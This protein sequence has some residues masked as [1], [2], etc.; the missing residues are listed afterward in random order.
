MEFS[1]LGRNDKKQTIKNSIMK[2]YLSIALLAFSMSV[3]VSCVSNFLDPE[4]P[5]N[6]QGSIS[7]P[8][9]ISMSLN[10]DEDIIVHYTDASIESSVCLKNKN[11]RDLPAGLEKNISV[12]VRYGTDKN[13][14]DNAIDAILDEKESDYRKYY[15][16][17]PFKANLTGLEDGQVYYYSIE[18][19]YGND[20]PV[21]CDAKKLFTFPAGPV[22]LDIKSGVLWCSGNLGAD[23][24]E[25]CGGR[26]A[27]AETSVKSENALY[28][29][30][31]YEWCSGKKDSI[32]KYCSSGYWGK[33]GFVDN[34]SEMQESDDA[35]HVQLG[36]GYHIP[37]ANDWI[38]LEEQCGWE[39][40]KVNG[41]NGWLVRSK[42]NPDDNKKVIFLPCTGIQ[43]GGSVM[44][45]NSSGYYWTANSVSGEYGAS[46][47]AY[48]FVIVISGI[49]GHY[50]YTTDRC[51]GESIRP[52]KK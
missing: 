33:D 29:W 51:Y 21:I 11:Y 28:D 45:R 34:L 7:L 44:N 26:Y 12:V 35:A 20:A 25:D 27:W 48:S 9:E 52:V 30:S 3:M 37:S 1:L 15:T 40:T 19:V 14:L 38:D 39:E 42:K 5:D 22:D 2:K 24:P 50:T 8:E 41:V 10:E 23:Y 13:R 36:E 46:Y 31:Y 49:S 6:K 43:E 18:V 16:S 32:T 47:Q 17:V 4:S